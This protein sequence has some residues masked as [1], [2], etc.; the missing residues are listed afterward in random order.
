MFS[1]FGVIWKNKYAR[2]TLKAIFYIV[3]LL[4]VF[5]IMQVVW[6]FVV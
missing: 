2:A 4:V 1:L 3:A 5:M 6:S